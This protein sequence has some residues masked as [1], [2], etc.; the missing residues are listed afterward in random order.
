MTFSLPLRKPVRDW[1]QLRNR[2]FSGFVIETDYENRYSRIT[3]NPE[4][5]RFVI[6][7][8]LKFFRN[9]PVFVNFP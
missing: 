6:G 4:I 7:I 1:H 8:D 5:F 3:L 9:F 2:N